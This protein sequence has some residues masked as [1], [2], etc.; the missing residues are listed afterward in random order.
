[1]NDDGE[2]DALW[3]G[4]FVRR[5]IRLALEEDLSFGDA[6]GELTVDKSTVADA[7]VLARQDLV[8][9]GLPIVSA[10]VEEWGGVSTLAVQAKEGSLAKDQQ[11]L[12]TLRG[13]ARE[14]LALER[15]ILNFLQ[16]LC[17]VATHTRDIVGGIP[18]LTVLD[19]RKTMPGW[20]VL[21]KY[22]TRI[23][24]ASN[25]RMHL[26]DLAMVKNNHVDANGGD[27]R[28]T[29]ERLF[30]NRAPYLPVEVEVR[31][32]K[33]LEVAADF[34]PTIIM[35]D[36]MK[37]AEVKASLE[38][39]ASKQCTSIVEISGGL[40]PDRLPRLAAMG[41]T[42]VSMGALVTQARNVDISLR[43]SVVERG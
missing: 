4:P 37:D 22:A 19:T 16:R 30:K 2:F 26:G 1:M 24:G 10:I 36:N 29:L 34:N 12:A 39:L 7:R 21:E 3:R 13:P 20:R 28:R 38:F 15:T 40:T 18:Q 23:G 41:V 9:C 31:D 6:A 25:H 43:M 11:T 27:M 8:V 32:R 35:L 42:H 14:L 17:G 33:E 5:L